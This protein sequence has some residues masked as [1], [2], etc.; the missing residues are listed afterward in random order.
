[1]CTVKAVFNPLMTMHDVHASNDV[2]E[3]YVLTRKT[4]TNCIHGL[5]PTSG[6]FA[7]ISETK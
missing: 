1:M 7:L 2:S 4:K 6:V 3:K 5:K